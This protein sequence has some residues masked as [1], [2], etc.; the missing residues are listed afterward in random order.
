MKTRLFE[1]FFTTKKEERTAAGSVWQLATASFGKAAAKCV[2]R[3]S[4]AAAR[5]SR[6]T[7]PNIRRPS[8][9]AEFHNPRQKKATHRDP[10]Q[11]SCS[12]TT[13]TYGTSPFVLLQG[14][15]YRGDRSRQCRRRA[16]PTSRRKIANAKF[17]LLLTDI[18]MPRMNGKDFAEWLGKTR[19]DT[20]VVFISGYLE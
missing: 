20:K 9:L 19:P 11:C 12:K 10:N 15:G 4:W 16:A 6:F 7:C 3:V 5:P 17:H 14:L 1:P 18:V 13:S 2:S 8:L